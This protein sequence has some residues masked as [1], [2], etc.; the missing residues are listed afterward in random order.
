MTG[1][2]KSQVKTRR[3]ELSWAAVLERRQVLKRN[4]DRSGGVGDG[5]DAVTGITGIAATAIAVTGT[6]LT[7]TAVTVTIAIAVT[8]IAVTAIVHIV[9][10][11][12]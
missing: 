1:L 9:T 12:V 10:S 5:S 8:A 3:E 11:V 2:Y 7:A 6:A 4:L